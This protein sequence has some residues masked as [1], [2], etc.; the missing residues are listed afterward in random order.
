ML[1][2]LQFIVITLLTSIASSKKINLFIRPV[3]QTT[4]DPIGFIENDA[5]YLMDVSLQP[6]QAY[7]IGTKDIHNN[8]C[9]SYQSNL[10]NLT[11]A[12]FSLF[13]DEDGDISRLSLS[14][15]DRLDKPQ[16]KKRK[17]VIAAQPNLNP[18]SMKKQRDEQQKKAGNEP[19]VEKVKQKKLIKEID[20]N[21]VE[22]TREIEEEVE[23][24]VDDR[25]WIQKNWMYIVPPLIIFMLAGGG[26]EQR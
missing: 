22:V 21:G 14:F 19:V 6:D 13:L 26:N 4:A 3:D 25:S 12:V 2:V 5:V 10:S 24:A 1:S 11:H 8:D 18:D 20:A 16:V 15:D 17:Q 23:V 7:C 9:F